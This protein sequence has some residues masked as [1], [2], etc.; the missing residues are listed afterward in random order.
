VILGGDVARAVSNHTTVFDLGPL[1][2]ERV[3][4]GAAL[5]RRTHL[6]VL[7]TGGVISPGAPPVA[8]LMAQSLRDDFAVDVRWIEPASKDTWENAELSAAILHQAGIHSAYVVTHAWHVRRASE[9]FTHF[10]IMVTAAPPRVD[11]SPRLRLGSFIPSA[12]AWMASYF[13]LH[14]WIGRIYYAC[15]ALLS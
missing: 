2:L 15:R 14:E 7:V 10:G 12:P 11:A 6:P 1:S 4:A 9:A 13:A 3:R 5:Q 8:V